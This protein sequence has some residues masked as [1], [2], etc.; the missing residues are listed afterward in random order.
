MCS[1]ACPVHVVS[2]R[3]RYCHYPMCLS[4]EHVHDRWTPEP[5]KALPTARDK[6]SRTNKQCKSQRNANGT[7]MKRYLFNDH[8]SH[9]SNTAINSVNWIRTCT[10]A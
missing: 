5:V 1:A 9:E 10:L 7:P 4:G 3:S 2:R 8:Q 6:T